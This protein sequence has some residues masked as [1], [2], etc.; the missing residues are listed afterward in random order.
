MAMIRVP[1]TRWVTR[2]D[3]LPCIVRVREAIE[4]DPARALD[5][6]SFAGI[7]GLSSFHFQRLFRET[8]GESATAF[9]RRVRFERACKLLEDGC[10]VTDACFQ[11]GFASVG[12]FSRVFKARYGVTPSDWRKSATADK[13]L[14]DSVV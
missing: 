7:A 13:R 6:A 8:F 1:A 2:A 5:L 11:V 10:S 9:H 12:S 4:G 3:L 14:A